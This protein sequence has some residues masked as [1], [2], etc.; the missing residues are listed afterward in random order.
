VYTRTPIL[1]A[2]VVSITPAPASSP[3]NDAASLSSSASTRARSPAPLPAAPQFTVDVE[4]TADGLREEGVA[5]DRIVLTDSAVP[6]PTPLLVAL[7]DVGQQIAS[8]T[9]NRPDIQQEIMN[10]V[11]VP[12]LSQMIVNRALDPV[13]DLLPILQYFQRSLQ[14]LQA[15]SRTAVSE[16]WIRDLAD[17]FHKVDSPTIAG[18]VASSGQ[19][20]GKSLDEVAP[21]LPQFFERASAVVEEIQRDMA[22]YYISVLV[23][24]L[25]AQGADYLRGKFQQRLLEGRV[26]LDATASLIYGQLLP[27]SALQETVRDLIEAGACAEAGFA[28]ADLVLAPQNV[29]TV[30][31][32]LSA[33]EGAAGSSVPATASRL[34]LVDGVVARAI[35]S[36]LQLPVRLDSPEAAHL[37]PEVLVWDAAR[38][39][40]IR[41]LVDRIALECS[42]VIA[43]KQVMA[44]YQLPP[45]CSDAAAEVELQHRLDVLLTEKDTSMASI[46]TEVVRYVQEALQK[47]RQAHLAATS[48]GAVFGAGGA[49]SR[50]LAAVPLTHPALVGGDT[51]EVH[52]RVSKGLKDVV[53]HGNP[54]LALFSKR[55]YKVLLRAMLGQGFKHLLP[56]YSLQS[57]AQQRNLSQ[58]IQSV[59]R[60]FAHTMKVHRDVYVVVVGRAVASTNDTV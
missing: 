38:L 41:D 20:R 53:A 59:C 35:L 29:P 33:P 56:S 34:S 57:P 25:Q 2:R 9:P 6:D 58:L 52:E 16:A 45:W 5:A 55:V 21:L 7:H 46:T 43:C 39:A 30:T 54:V 8:F 44:R 4:Y 40:S 26:G 19:R 14:S 18:A 10:T 48:G 31:S 42:L 28:L 27:E 51:Q 17:S 24:V 22:N 1:T 50:A 37:M 49:S 11:D 60:L 36:L 32:A 23:P 13:T 12:L 47:F 15:P 3:V